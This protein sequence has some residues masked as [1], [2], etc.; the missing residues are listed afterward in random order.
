MLNWN[1]VLKYIKGRLALPST[2][3]EK[4]DTQIQDWITM[5]AIPEF[6]LY[7]PSNA[8]TG[9]K[10]DVDLYK[11]PTLQHVY[12]FYD[13]EE[14][15]ILGIKDI[16]FSQ[17]DLFINGHPFMGPF[18]L[19]SMR[20]W[21]LA[22]FQAGLLQQYSNFNYTWKFM[23][24]NKVRILG[25]QLGGFGE[26]V[27]NYEREQPSDLREIPASM[28]M[29]FMDLALAHVQIQIGNMRSYYGDGRLTTPFGDLPLNGDVLK[30]DG[31]TLRDKIIENLSMSSL[32]PC[33]IDIG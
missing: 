1:T 27:I 8:V 16:Y 24:P 23:P 21:A 29:L 32:P 13:D 10:S 9:I 5:T 14:L 3:I 11:D 26:A 7:F 31:E 6:S 12:L 22:A 20:E 4:N 17:G 2:F 33:I 15:D 19:Q 25:G 28:K 30:S 18:T